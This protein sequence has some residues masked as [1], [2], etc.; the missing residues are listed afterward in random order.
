MEGPQT[1]AAI[2]VEPIT[3]TNGILILRRLARTE[4]LR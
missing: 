3:G 1:V 4:N 2:I